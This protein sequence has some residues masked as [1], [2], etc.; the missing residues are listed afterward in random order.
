MGF[1]SKRFGMAHF[2]LAVVGVVSGPTTLQRRGLRDL[3]GEALRR[4]HDRD[5]GS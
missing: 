5:E 2:V 3:I 4:V 1:A